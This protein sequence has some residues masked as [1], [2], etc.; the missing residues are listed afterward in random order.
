[1]SVPDL[2]TIDGFTWDVAP[3]PVA[4]G[5]EPVTMLHSDAYCISEGTG[6][7]DA[8]W[9]FVEFAMTATGQRV[10][11]ESGRTVPSRHDVLASEAFQRPDA[12]PANAQVFVDNAEIA[13]ATP[14][15]ASWAQVEKLAD[16]ILEGIFYGRV[17]PEAGI[18]R[19][20]DQTRAAFHRAD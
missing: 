6:D 15:T 10:L 14:S 20:L 13:R 12:P 9:R 1:V 2:R 16:D 17:E 3:L 11:A 7:E 5:G 8:A 18:Q 19:L 4:P